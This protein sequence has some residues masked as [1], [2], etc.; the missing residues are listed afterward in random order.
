V[1]RPDGLPTNVRANPPPK[2]DHPLTLV[3]LLVE[4]G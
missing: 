1:R 2:E 4:L 3:E